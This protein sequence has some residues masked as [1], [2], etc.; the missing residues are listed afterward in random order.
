M[1]V[2]RG[3]LVRVAV[4]GGVAVGGTGVAVGGGGV[5]VTVRLPVPVVQFAV[6]VAV[7]ADMP[8]A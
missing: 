1:L 8:V 7:P 5:T 4:G 6:T 3:V 2:G